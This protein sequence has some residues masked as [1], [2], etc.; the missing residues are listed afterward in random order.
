MAVDGVS[1]TTQTG[2][3]GNAYT[4]AV[5]SDGLSSDDFLKLMLEEMKQ[6]DPT[7]PMDTDKLMDS[8]LKISTIQS[9]LKMATAMESLQSS[10]A[11]SA[12]STASNLIGNVI[13]DGSK[14]DNGDATK[15][16]VTKVENK[17]GDLYVDALKITGQVDALV[18][19]DGKYV[20]YDAD[21]TIYESDGTTPTAYKVALD[22]DGR[23]TYNKDGSLKI[24]TVADN[25]PVTDEAVTSKYKFGGTGYKYADDTSSIPVGNITM[26]E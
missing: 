4:S 26:V 24:L 9:N 6:Q 15:Y 17:D 7:N 13:Q 5:S 3:D 19:S 20:L 21:G 11:T 23:F 8:Q 10:Y 25:E 2:V 18:D 1:T 22:R 16:K 14:D 12:L